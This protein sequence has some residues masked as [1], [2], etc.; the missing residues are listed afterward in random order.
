MGW[1]ATSSSNQVL[2]RF[3]LERGRSASMARAS[4]RAR[5]F[6]AM[7][8]S[9]AAPSAPASSSSSLLLLLPPLLM[10]SSSSSSSPLLSPAKSTLQ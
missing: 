3:F 8:G 1:V 7:S 5:C 4:S 10:Y 2:L 9:A 6:A